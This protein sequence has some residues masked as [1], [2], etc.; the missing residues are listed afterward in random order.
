MN[1][2]LWIAY[3][4]YVFKPEPHSKV[5]T[6]IFS[7]YL[8]E[9][10]LAIEH[11]HAQGII[12][13]DLKPENILLD[14]HGESEI[15]LELCAKINLVFGYFNRL[16]GLLPYY[17]MDQKIMMF[18]AGLLLLAGMFISQ[19]VFTWNVIKGRLWNWFASNPI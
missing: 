10:T 2:K 9:I 11:L 16:H 6:S 19:T 17:V 12:Y 7:F 14:H 1:L 4:L 8:A 18:L 5:N 3:I 13:R 15:V